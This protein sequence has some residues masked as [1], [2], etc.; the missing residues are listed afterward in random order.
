MTSLFQDAQGFI[1]V[2]LFLDSGVKR[3]QRNVPPGS[4]KTCRK[5]HDGESN[6]LFFFSF[7]FFLLPSTRCN[8]CC[9]DWKWS[10]GRKQCRALRSW[11]LPQQNKVGPR[12]GWSLWGSHRRR[13]QLLLLP[14]T[15]WQF[16]DNG[17]LFIVA[18]S[19]EVKT[20][21]VTSHARLK[22]KQWSLLEVFQRRDVGG[23]EIGMKVVLNFAN[24]SPSV[25]VPDTKAAVVE[26]PHRVDGSTF[27][28]FFLTFSHIFSQMTFTGSLQPDIYHCVF[29]HIK[30][31]FSARQICISWLNNW[32]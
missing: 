13:K 15:S 20:L 19:T 5:T 30:L 27:A 9:R 8:L 6:K 26:C 24:F 3:V 25:F 23:L 21:I 7:Y 11:L 17:R 14:A 31:S 29:M 32:R 10:P 1:L 18:S 22:V 16:P 28:P 4:K 2:F 12:D